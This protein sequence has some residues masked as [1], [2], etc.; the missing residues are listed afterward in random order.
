MILHQV[1]NKLSLL[2][3][4]PGK[5]SKNLISAQ[6]AYSNNYGTCASPFLVLVLAISCNVRFVGSMEAPSKAFLLFFLLPD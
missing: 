6:G 3:K 5:K 1:M 2:F 4:R